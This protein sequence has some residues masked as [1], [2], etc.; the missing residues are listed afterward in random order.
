L[1]SWHFITNNWW[2]HNLRNTLCCRQVGDRG[3]KIK[4]KVCK[5]LM[6]EHDLVYDISSLRNFF[7]FWFCDFWI[8]IFSFGKYKR[9]FQLDC[10]HGASGS[11]DLIFK[12]CDCIIKVE[13]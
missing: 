9:N 10:M 8:V 4:C 3:M 13:K 12:G 2:N 11:G 7:R 6:S 1:G 5:H